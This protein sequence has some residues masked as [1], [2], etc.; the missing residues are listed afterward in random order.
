MKHRVIVMMALSVLLGLVL[1]A[2]SGQ[3]KPT[4]TAEATATPSAE[5]PTPEATVPIGGVDVALQNVLKPAVPVVARVNGEDITTDAYMRELRTQLYYVTN[6]YSVNWFDQEAIGLIPSFQDQVVQQMVQSR[7][8]EQLA[9]AEKMDVT[10]AEVQAEAENSKQQVLAGGTYKTWDEALAGMGIT[11]EDYLAQNRV[12]LLYSKLLKV[13][14]GPDTA[15]QVHAAHILVADENT[16]N[17]VLAKLKEGKAFADLAKEY[18]TDMGSKDQGGDLGWFPRGAMVP[19]FEEAAFALKPGETSGLVKSDYGYHIIQLL[20]KELRPLSADVLQNVEQQ[21]FQ[22][23][24]EAEMAKAKVETLVQFE[25]P[26]PEPT[27]T[28]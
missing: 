24:F 20:G 5:V 12:Y 7:L 22:T 17:E 26:A 3:A 13:H 19:E 1:A 23:W 2:C 21:N 25:Q 27:P 10:A 28:A 6:S 15:E 14:G 8:L 18:S 9:N 16:G 4:P 11:E